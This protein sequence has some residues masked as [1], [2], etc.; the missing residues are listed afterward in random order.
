MRLRFREM[1]LS[2]WL[3]L[4]GYSDSV[5]LYFSDVLKNVYVLLKNIF[6]WVFVIFYDGSVSVYL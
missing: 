3:F 5:D 2:P 1:L 4:S 6:E